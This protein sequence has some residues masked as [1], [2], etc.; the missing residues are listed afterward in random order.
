MHPCAIFQG[1]RRRRQQSQLHIRPAR[2]LEMS[3]EAQVI[4]RDKS[5]VLAPARFSA[6]RWPATAMS[7]ELAHAPA[8]RA[9]ARA[10]RS[11]KPPARLRGESSRP[12]AFPVTTVPKP[13]MVNTRSIGSRAIACESR[14]CT[15]AAA[16]T[17]A[18]LSSSSPAPVNELTATIEW[19]CPVGSIQECPAQKLFYFQSHDFQRLRI[20]RVG[21]GQYRDAALHAQQ[22][23]DVEMLARLRLDRFIRCNHQQHQIDPAHARQHVAHK[24][25]VPGNVDKAQPQHVSPVSGRSGKSMCAKPRSMVMPRRFSSSSRSAS[26]PVRAFTSAVLPWSM[27]PAVPTMMDFIWAAILPEKPVA[28][29]E[30]LDRKWRW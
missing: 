3:P 8:R 30:S 27:C 10:A 13:F 15:R 18:R 16:P 26:I 4:P 9:R 2:C 25:L 23:Q 14:G 28:T 12:P 24:A 17:I 29:R 5:S 1:T 22:L 20:H 19:A 7:A 11:E 6:V 21:F